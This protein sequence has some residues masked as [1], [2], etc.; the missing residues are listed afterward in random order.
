MG[1]HQWES[2]TYFM[3]LL[4][5]FPTLRALTRLF[6]ILMFSSVSSEPPFHGNITFFSYDCSGPK[7]NITS[8]YGHFLS[9][10]PRRVKN[11]NEADLFISDL[12]CF[13]PV[14]H[15]LGHPVPKD[16]SDL[17][18]GKKHLAAT[19]LIFQH[20]RPAPS[21]ANLHSRLPH[22]MVSN[23]APPFF[24]RG[25]DIC[26]S[27][28]KASGGNFD[29]YNPDPFAR[30]HSCPIMLQRGTPN[31][32]LSRKYLAT[33]MGTNTIPERELLLPL[34][35]PSRNII[36]AMDCGIGHLETGKCSEFRKRFVQYDYC[37]S[38]NATFVLAPAGA[39]PNSHRFMEALYSGAIPVIFYPNSRGGRRNAL[40][41]D[42]VIN[43][44]PCASILTSVQD[45]R[46]LLNESPE[47]IRT[48][49]K[50][51]SYI[52]DM[53]FSNMHKQVDTILASA[54]KIFNKTNPCPYKKR[55]KPWWM[56]FPPFNHKILHHS[57]VDIWAWL[58]NSAERAAAEV[59]S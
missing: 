50:E 36:I 10:H 27:L 48:R 31:W 7:W 21:F 22:A 2:I 15:Q 24:R 25:Y 38:M 23:C 13:V 43:W 56:P 29:A 47:Q 42:D 51:C 26:S 45:I 12:S 18:L 30:N 52:F 33:F 19:I 46:V 20:D 55:R 5:S 4:T 39:E 16:M 17:F 57:I 58:I 34:H 49:Q 6:T 40:P 32:N 59:A 3:C 44:Q 37:D 41:F 35:D 8:P 54:V 28:P 53:H 1:I 11:P 14:G 9:T